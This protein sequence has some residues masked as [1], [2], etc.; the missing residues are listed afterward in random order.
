VYRTI[1]RNLAVLAAL[2]VLWSAG[3]SSVGAY[4]TAENQFRWHTHAGNSTHDYYIPVCINNNMGSDWNINGNSLHMTLWLAMEKWSQ[5]DRQLLYYRTNTSCSTLRTQGNI[6]LELKWVTAV[7]GGGFAQTLLKTTRDGRA[8]YQVIEFELEDQVAC[9]T[10]AFDDIDTCNW[11]YYNQ[12][13]V[14]HANGSGGSTPARYVDLYYAA[15]HEIGHA[16]G[17]DHNWAWDDCA[18]MMRNYS[19]TCY[20]NGRDWSRSLAQDD[21]NGFNAVWP[22]YP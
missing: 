10:N 18:A 17:L 6:F 16:S 13:P 9:V 3:V 5:L 8:E 2:A 19:G 22:D 12:T 4:A 7:P 14:D 11:T 20:P 1:R 21:I 15:I